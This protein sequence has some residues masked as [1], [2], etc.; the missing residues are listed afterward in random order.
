MR[1]LTSCCLA[2]L[3]YTSMPS[4]ASH[5]AE[6]EGMFP[7]FIRRNQDEWRAHVD[8]QGEGSRTAILE[9]IE[10][11]L[12]TAWGN[13][14]QAALFHQGPIDMPTAGE[15]VLSF[16]H[17]HGDAPL[18]K[19]SDGSD[20][21]SLGCA[22]WLDYVKRLQQLIEIHDSSGRSLS[23]SRKG[24][25]P[26]ISPPSSFQNPSPNP[27]HLRSSTHGALERSRQFGT[28]STDGK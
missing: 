7:G 24:K 9:A 10:N 4:A 12:T 8:K 13:Y 20:L 26:S 25:D 21:I 22:T 17:D 2:F 14:R 11:K 15:M 23:T 18:V 6:P 1:L 19:Q 16:R 3:F 27:G 5:E 28:F